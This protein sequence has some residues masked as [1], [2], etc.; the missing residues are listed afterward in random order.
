[1][2]QKAQHARPYR[3]VPPFLRQLREEAEL[4]QRA[5]GDLLGKPQSW[6]H[7]CE[8]GNRRVDVTEFIE[9]CRA[10]DTKPTVA[11]ARLAGEDRR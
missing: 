11:L 3:V 2:P 7:N 8:T 5:L 1:M 9:W 4:T 10:C 6:V